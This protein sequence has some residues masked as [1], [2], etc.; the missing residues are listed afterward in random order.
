MFIGNES[1]DEYYLILV[2]PPRQK[3]YNII[4]PR[5]TN[6][7]RKYS[8][9]YIHTRTRENDTT[10]VFFFIFCKPVIT[11]ILVFGMYS[12]DDVQTKR[13][14]TQAIVENDE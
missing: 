11:I 5:K 9:I 10:I 4:L 2:S 6:S 14:S 7:E 3:I 13:K 12:D 1:R 8:Y